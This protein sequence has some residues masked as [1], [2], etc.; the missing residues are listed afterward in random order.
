VGAKED[1]TA[2]SEGCRLKAMR[3]EQKNLWDQYKVSG[4]AGVIHQ[5]GKKRKEKWYK[6]SRLRSRLSR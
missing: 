1:S 5:G 2:G 6:V 4:G 3:S